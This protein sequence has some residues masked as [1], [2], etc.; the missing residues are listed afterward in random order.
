VGQTEG[1]FQGM[2][3]ANNGANKELVGIMA[4]LIWMMNGGTKLKL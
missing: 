1:R 2:E 4:L 3:K